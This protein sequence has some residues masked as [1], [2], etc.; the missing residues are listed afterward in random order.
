VLPLGGYGGFSYLILPALTVA[1]RS[2]AW[3]SR[4]LRASMLEIITADYVRTAHSK[5]LA[6]RVVIW[7]H[8]LRNALGPLIC[9]WGMD[10]GFF[11]SGLVVVEA[12][13]GWPGIGWLSWTAVRHLDIPLIMGTVQLAALIVIVMNL[14]VDIGTAWVDPRVRYT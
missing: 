6:P 13:F 7:G 4:V 5:G 1:I 10:F 9:V 11:F 8:I 3:Y 2:A 14:V 12:V